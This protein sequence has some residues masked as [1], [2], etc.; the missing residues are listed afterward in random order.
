MRTRRA[1]IIALFRLPL[2]GGIAF[3]CQKL[4]SASGLRTGAGARNIVTTI[5]DVMFPGD[6]APSAVSLGIPDAVKTI[7]GI[8]AVTRDG[9][10]WLNRWAS[11][12]GVPDFLSLDETGK[13]HAL[14]AALVSDDD[15]ASQ[16]VSLIRFHAG[17]AY[18]SDPAVKA[19]FPYT[20]PPQPDGFGNFAGPPL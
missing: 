18:Y 12:Q 14:E 1:L 3:L 8:D 2:V 7:A 11:G 20:G 16:F 13:Q 4:A 6:A 9:A 5:I 19:T 15:S 10:A 17:L